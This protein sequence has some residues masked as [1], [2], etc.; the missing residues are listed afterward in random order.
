MFGRLGWLEILVIVVLLVILFGSSKI[1]AMMKNLASG[2]N[3]F[4]KEMK[5]TDE[6]SAT[7]KTEEVKKP[8][9]KTKR[10]VKAKK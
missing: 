5:K 6:K 4:K 9:R 1:P 7:K 2:I 8:V 3:T 10:T